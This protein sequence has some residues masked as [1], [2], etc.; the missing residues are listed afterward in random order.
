MTHIVET[1]TH[2]KKY[3]RI[4]N[5]ESEHLCFDIFCEICLKRLIVARVVDVY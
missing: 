1:L 3:Y 5:N 4:K 2:T